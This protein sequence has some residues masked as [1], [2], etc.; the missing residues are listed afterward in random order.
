MR[1]I[2]YACDC[3]SPFFRGK[4][5]D[6]A[7]ALPICNLMR[8]SISAAIWMKQIYGPAQ[9]DQLLAVVAKRSGAAIRVL[10]NPPCEPVAPFL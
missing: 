3:P 2:A 10:A 4:S 8:L 7:A 9:C 6:S 5:P 1:H